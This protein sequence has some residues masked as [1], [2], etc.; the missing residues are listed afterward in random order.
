MTTTYS[1]RPLAGHSLN[2][3]PKG[4]GIKG[5]P[6]GTPTGEEL[7]LLL[8]S[9]QASLERPIMRPAEAIAL[10]SESYTML[11][12]FQAALLADPQSSLGKEVA[13]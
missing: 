12:L 3:R 1:Q 4:K 10:L 6:W 7:A 9:L 11:L 8:D 2:W 5:Q 13:A